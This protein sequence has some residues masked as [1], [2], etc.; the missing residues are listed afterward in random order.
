VLT[1]ERLVRTGPVSRSFCFRSGSPL[2][3]KS[4]Y[5]PESARNLGV[6]SGF[7]NPTRLI[8]VTDALIDGTGMQSR[9]AAIVLCADLA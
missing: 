1:F 4:Y 7:V 6:P 8:F 5:L 2:E 3:E 9:P